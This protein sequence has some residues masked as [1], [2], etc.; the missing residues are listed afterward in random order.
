MRIAI[1]QPTLVSRTETFIRAHAERLPGVVA[2]IAGHPLTWQMPYDANGPIQSPVLTARVWRRAVRMATGAGDDD[3]TAGYRKA[4]RRCRADLVL[5]E[6]GTVGAVVLD[7][8]RQ[9]R[10]PLVVYFRGSDAT[11]RP[12]VEKFLPH[13]GPMFE[14]A[15]AVVTVSADLRRRVL[16]MGAP[17]DRTFVTPSGADC[18]AFTP[19]KPAE[20][21]PTFVAAGRFVDKKAPHHTIE[22]FAA[23]LRD[24]PELRL[25][26]IGDG[27]LLP[28]CR[29][30][31]NEA[32]IDHAVEFLGFLPHGRVAQEMTRARG[33][34]QH[35]VE[36]ADGDCEG[37][38]VAV[39]EAGAAGL[40]VVATCHGG[41][42]DVVAHG[43]T[44]LLVAEGDVA[45]M[46]DGLRTLARDGQLAG[47]MGAAAAVRIRRHFSTRASV[48]RLTRILQCSCRGF[49]DVPV[50]HGSAEIPCSG[51]SGETVPSAAAVP[52][53]SVVIPC[54]N[55]AAFLPETLASVRRQ[56]RPPLEVIVVDDGS[57]DTSAEIAAAFGPP[58]RVIRQENQGESVARNRGIEQARGDWIAFLD[59]D[60][61]WTPDRLARHAAVI[62]DLP[63]DVVCCFNGAYR[64]D[65]SGRRPEPPGNDSLMRSWVRTE[66]ID[67]RSPVNMICNGGVL[68]SCAL[69]RRSALDGVRFAVDVRVNEDLLFFVALR[70]RGRFYR[71]NEPLTGWRCR[72]GQ[73]SRASDYEYEAVRT[74]LKWLGEQDDLAD[75]QRQAAQASV[76]ARLLKAHE[77][78]YWARDFAT[79]RRCRRLYEQLHAADGAAGT[80]ACLRRTLWPQPLYRLKDGLD[81]QRSRWRERCGM[82]VPSLAG[83]GAES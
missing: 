60:D 10:L 56:S 21:Q 1:V 64:F 70:R 3:R 69:V 36:S 2:V 20:N 68:P 26:M 48:E 42:G 52:S 66:G 14:Y 50:E 19:T 67:P 61:V 38:P 63:E 27:P 59:A 7:A 29:R 23:A 13:Y 46:A 6:F 62:A 16:A 81:R 76:T 39:M 28:A 25:R 73:Q 49:F 35:S 22:A 24:V 41:I 43:R 45:G 4:L 15:A 82:L 5:A 80:P 78:A 77:L 58:V 9:L 75:D 37:T 8:C 18:D 47:R 55:A 34:V 40:P 51:S 54:Y 11:K 65:E 32:G 74:R 44:G 12:I 83:Q 57:T 79:V 33:F 31:V 72:P 30:Q 71:I 53:V 17:S